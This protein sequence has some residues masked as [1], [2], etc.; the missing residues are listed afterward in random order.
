MKYIGHDY[1]S[2]T[3]LVNVCSANKVYVP[4]LLIYSQ[5]SPS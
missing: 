3:K 2:S 4:F 5:F 1:L